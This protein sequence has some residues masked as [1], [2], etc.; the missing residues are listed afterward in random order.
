MSRTVHLLTI[1]L[2]DIDFFKQAC[3]GELFV[4]VL[5]KGKKHDKYI[6]EIV[7]DYNKKRNI[8]SGPEMYKGLTVPRFKISMALIAQL[9]GVKFIEPLVL[10]RLTNKRINRTPQR[11]QEYFVKLLVPGFWLVGTVIEDSLSENDEI[12]RGNPF[13]FLPGDLGFWWAGSVIMD[14]M[15][16]DYLKKKDEKNYKSCQEFYNDCN[17]SRK[18][19]YCQT[20]ALSHLDR[21]PKQFLSIQ[22]EKNFVDTIENVGIDEEA[23]RAIIKNH[24]GIEI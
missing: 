12:N 4:A 16:Y 22:D 19:K 8:I 24:F 18:Y 2:E 6:R 10:R 17:L 23:I 14:W 15:N 20:S 5:N 9:V 21:I 13:K 11:F 7:D 3:S 1:L